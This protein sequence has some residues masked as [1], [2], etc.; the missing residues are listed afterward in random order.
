MNFLHHLL[1]SAAWAFAISPLCAQFVVA[2]SDAPSVIGADGQPLRFPWT[3]GLNA[4]D[5]STF[6]ADFDGLVDDLYI[7]DK[8][9]NRSLVFLGQMIDGQ[10]RYTYSIPHSR[11]FPPIQSWALLRDFDCD[12]RKDLFTYGTQGGAISVYR[13]V[14]S[15]SGPGWELAEEVLLSHYD[16]G[17]TEYT[18]NIY[19]S[20][21]DVPAVFDYDGDGDLDI[22]TS[23][24]GGT[25]IEFHFNQSMESGA[26]CGLQHFELANRCYGGFLEGE[27]SNT[28]ILDP[29]EFAQECTFNVVNPKSHPPTNDRRGARHVGST[30]LAADFNDDGLIDLVL[31]DAGYSN[32]VYLENSDGDQGTDQIVEFDMDFPSTFGVPGIQLDQFVSAY[33]EDVTGDG[34]P[35]LLASVNEAQGSANYN[36]IYLY[37][38]IGATASP[39]FTSPIRNFLQSETLDYGERSAPAVFDFNGDGVD[40]LIISARGRYHQGA[41]HPQLVA[42]VRTGTAEQPAFEVVETDWLSLSEMEIESPKPTFGDL[43]GNGAADLLIGAEAGGVHR[44]VNTGTASAPAFEYLGPM[45]SGTAPIS[46]GSHASPQLFDLDSDGLL[47]LIIGNL[48]G[49]LA[50]YRNV[51]TATNAE[52]SLI[53]TELGGV[54][55]VETPPFFTGYS[56]PHFFRHEGQTHLVCGSKSGNLFL[57][58]NIDGN[59]D[60]DFDL[61][62]TQAFD[63]YQPAMSVPSGRHTAPLVYDWNGDGHPDLMVG[64]IGGGIEFFAG[65]DPDGL[66]SASPRGGFG[67]Y[68]NPTAGSIRLVGLEAWRSPRSLAIY[69]ATGRMLGHRP[70]SDAPLEVGTLPPGLYLV[71]VFFDSGH[72]SAAKFVVSP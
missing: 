13:N 3:G 51:G 52:F 60:G 12:G 42:L 30:I 70:Y 28:I 15:A 69:S 14:G 49:H 54:S 66:A 34:I 55:T 48:D 35:D 46:V 23:N 57:Y 68:P 45:V 37:E 31:G 29:D 56:S 24:V 1:L 44:F 6:D 11:A 22:L 27:E 63:A 62:T 41:Y 36:S 43:T 17:T 39:I 58:D 7:Y 64:G 40:D 20:S 8:A 18:T 26:G 10:R 38:N 50:Y 16:F 61:L 47:D 33:Y 71:R 5:V 59:L 53:T 19:C 32:L 25:F 4:V 21:Q 67:V 72:S 2:P 9:G 65:Y